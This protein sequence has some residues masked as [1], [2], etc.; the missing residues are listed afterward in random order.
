MPE[1]QP[2]MSAPTLLATS[3]PLLNPMLEMSANGDVFTLE[4]RDAE[5]SYKGDSATLM[6]QLAQRL[7]GDTEITVL[8]REFGV[9]DQSIFNLLTPLREENLVLDANWVGRADGADQFAG[10]FV[11][12]CR[13][14]SQVIYAQPFWNTVLSGAAGRN[15]VLG[16]GME[17]THFVDAANEYM[18]AGVAYCRDNPTI[19]EWVARHYVEEADHAVIFLNGLENCGFE[20]RQLLNAPPLATTRAL[21]NF[22]NETAILGTVAYSAVFSLMQPSVEPVAPGAI[23]QFYGQLSGQYP[24]AKPMF[25]AYCRHALIDVELEHEQTLI[26]RLCRSPRSITPQEAASAVRVVRALAEH[27]IVFFEGIADYYGCS[28]AQFP[29]RAVKYAAAP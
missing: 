5:W 8:A 11:A 16:W 14:W 26:S 18:A 27:F 7:R 10:A 13:F 1:H 28:D 22:L 15:V 23:K 6:R 17:F 21:I 29:R 20:R 9:S 12:E 4:T 3:R 2:S 19:R 24:F 25:D